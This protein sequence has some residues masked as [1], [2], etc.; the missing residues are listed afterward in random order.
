MRAENIVIPEVPVPIRIRRA[1]K[2][3]LAAQK[4]AIKKLHLKRKSPQKALPRDQ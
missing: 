2:K 4:R 1:S 3:K